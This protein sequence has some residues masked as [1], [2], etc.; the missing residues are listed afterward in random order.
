MIYSMYAMII[1]TFVVAGYLLKL[2]IDAV[3]TGALKLSAF[4]LNIPTEMPTTILQ[5][6]RNYSNLFEMPTFFY[7]AGTLAIILNMQTPIMIV[8]SWFFV[9]S[10]AVHSWIHITSNN[11]IRRLQAFIV[12]NVCMLL[13]WIILVWQYSTIHMY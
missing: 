2:R 3:K 10:R 1:L 13:M 6:A 8:L 11:V 7:I 12:S 9:F 4:R 5:T